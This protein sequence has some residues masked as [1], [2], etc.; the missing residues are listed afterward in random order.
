M[1]GVFRSSRS[2]DKD[3]HLHW[4]N[5]MWKWRQRL[6]W[7]C[8]YIPR[9][10]KDV[11]VT[12]RARGEEGTDLSPQTLEGINLTGSLFL[13]FRS[14]KWEPTNFYGLSYSGC[15]TWYK[16]LGNKKPSRDLCGSLQFGV[17]RQRMP[18]AISVRRRWRGHSASSHPW[19]CTLRAFGSEESRIQALGR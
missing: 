10:P 3:T 12:T 11:L 17:W 18:P 6:W 9:N 15:G 4:E 8:F 5:P 14:P 16:F 13:A 2:F 1:T 19:Q 7:G